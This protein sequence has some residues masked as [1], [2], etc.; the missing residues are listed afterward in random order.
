M[1]FFMGN[2]ATISIFCEDVVAAMQG[3]EQIITRLASPGR[4]PLA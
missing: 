2:G 4:A 3:V 1:L